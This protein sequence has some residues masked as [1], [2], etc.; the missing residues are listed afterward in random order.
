MSKLKFFIFLLITAGITLSAAPGKEIIKF[1][2]RDKVSGK[3]VNNAKVDLKGIIDNR[4]I[5][6]YVQFTDKHGRCSFTVGDSNQAAYQVRAT[7]K[8]MV[9]YYDSTYKDLDRSFSFINAATGNTVELWLTSDTLNH[10]KFWAA[11]A[12]KYNIDQLISMLKNDQYPLRSEI[13]V[14]AWE[15]IPALLALG[16]DTNRIDKYPVSVLSS[17]MPG[18]CYLGIVSLWFVESARIALLKG[19]SNPNERFPS[20]TP[21]L[22]VKESAGMNA[23]SALIMEQGYRAY[24]EWWNKVKN[25]NKEDGCKIN[26]LENTNLEWR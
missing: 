16:N 20:M 25:M 19:T 2:V 9:G 12:T 18:K 4:D 22:S 8:G 23:N 3:P 15:D 1:T 14:I 5:V 7:G 13:P 17:S 10:E 26:P 6:E 21:N 24:Q 11:R